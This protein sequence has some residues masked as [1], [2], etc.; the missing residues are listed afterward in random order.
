MTDPQLGVLMLVLFIFLIMLG[1][2]DRLHADG[3]G[4]RLRLPRL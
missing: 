3:D 4:R 1:F 2:P